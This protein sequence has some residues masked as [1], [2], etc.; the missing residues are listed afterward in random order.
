MVNRPGSPEN[1]RGGGSE[2]KALEKAAVEKAA[3]EREIERDFIRH[4]LHRTN[5]AMQ[6]G[7]H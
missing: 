4:I 6:P 1:Q 2:E 7:S 3:R 5:T